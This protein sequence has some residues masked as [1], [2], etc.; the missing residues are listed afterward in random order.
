LAGLAFAPSGLTASP[1][2]FPALY[3]RAD[4][5]LYQAKAEGKNRVVLA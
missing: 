5:A 2:E 1:A 3:R 4:E